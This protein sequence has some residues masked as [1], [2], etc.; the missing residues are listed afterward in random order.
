MFRVTVEATD[1]QIRKYTAANLRN[2]FRG[3][4]GILFERHSFQRMS[5]ITYVHVVPRQECHIYVF[6]YIFF[7][8]ILDT[9]FIQIIH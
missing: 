2:T 9:R 3:K 7:K 1:L 5:F 6:F 4:A 8:K